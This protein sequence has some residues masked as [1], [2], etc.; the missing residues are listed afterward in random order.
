MSIFGWALNKSF[1]LATMFTLKKYWYPLIISSTMNVPHM[2]TSSSLA[3]LL[4]GV[5]PVVPVPPGMVENTM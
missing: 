3:P 1:T 4:T 2:M 5:A